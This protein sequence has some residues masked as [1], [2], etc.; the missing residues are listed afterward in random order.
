[1]SILVNLLNQFM[2]YIHRE[3]IN[4][5]DLLHPQQK[6][7]RIVVAEPETELFG[8]YDRHFSEEGLTAHHCRELS[9]LLGHLAN[10]EPHV[11]VVSLEFREGI[12]HTRRFLAH[13]KKYYPLT[14]L[15]TVSKGGGPE[16]M[17]IPMQLGVSGHINRQ[18]SRPQDVVMI[19]K[20]ILNN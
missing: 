3:K 7:Y 20:A 8:I 1:M 2:P 10:L 15:I 9:S 12:E 5:R 4:F 14:H 11:L 19:V 18:L 6:A 13:I 17:K 16:H